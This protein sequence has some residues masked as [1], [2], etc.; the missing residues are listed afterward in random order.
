MEDNHSVLDATLLVLVELAHTD[1]EYSAGEHA[2][3]VAILSQMFGYDA[4]HVAA[5]LDEM[6]SKRR[7]VPD[8]VRLSREI[9]ALVP[10]VSARKQIV[11]A[12]WRVVQSD[13]IINS[14]EDQIAF[15]LSMMLGC[16]TKEIEA[17]REG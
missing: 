16:S 13:D 1:K 2:E 4:E 12:M 10:D 3:I 14:L 17:F 8:L 11:R 7:G 15:S 5:K 6:V 9:N